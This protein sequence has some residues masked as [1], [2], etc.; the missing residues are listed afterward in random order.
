MAYIEFK[1]DQKFAEI[2]ADVSHN[3]EYFR[4]AG[5]VIENNE[6]I[7]DIDNVSRETI[8]NFISVFDIKT[9]IVWTDRGVHLY[10]VHS[11]K[12][13]QLPAEGITALGFKA[14]YKTAKRNKNITIKRN[15]ILRTIDNE[16]QREV[17]PEWLIANDRFTELYGH[18]E[19]DGRNNALF[20]HGMSLRSMY[21]SKYTAILQFINNHVF[22]EPLENNEF[23]N[24]LQSI[25]KREVSASKGN[26]SMIAK[27]LIELY[28]VRM[29]ED[30]L[31]FKPHSS[32]K[33]IHNNTRLE[34]YIY[35][36]CKGEAN[37]KYVKE[38]LEQ[39]KLNLI[40]KQVKADNFKVVFN[41]GVLFNGEFVE[42]D[43]KEFSPYYVDREYKKDV[44]PVEAVDN[45]LNHFT[46]GDINFKNI[47]FEMM[48]HSLITDRHFKGGLRS[49]FIIVGSAGTGKSLLIK[50]LREII[51]AENTTNVALSKI[52]DHRY[53]VN[54][55]GKLLNIGD[56]IENK[57]IDDGTMSTLK[58]IASCDPMQLRAMYEASSDITVTT[59]L[60]FTSN[61]MLKSF[62]KSDA[63][64]S[65]VKWLPAYN[66]PQEKDIQLFH[67]LTTDDAVS[68]WISE[69]IEGYKRLYANQQFT[70]SDK[71][72]EFNKHYHDQNNPVLDYID[73]NDLTIR[74]FIGCTR[75]STYMIYSNWCKE[76]NIRPIKKLTFYEGVEDKFNI[77]E[78]RT[79]G[80]RGWGYADINKQEAYE[81]GKIENIGSYQVD[82]R[83][84]KLK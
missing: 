21:P 79:K 78:T 73:E 31:Y 64:K 4:D 65:R 2:G 71:V 33:Y 68:Y 47:I 38:I 20:S 24:L 6:I 43:Y 60:M 54:L 49:F 55:K 16:N 35:D 67:K 53:A 7:I 70:E 34:G 48:A 19:G 45:Y 8:S 40:N 81:S 23:Q 18:Q 50:V 15:N 61:H 56:D 3:H 36:Y 76:M 69:I 1:Q 32:R 12:S 83:M 62:D 37:S 59:S 57:P 14:E 39:I 27:V 77:K 74:S 42:V 17:I 29:Y 66:K 58:N 22:S 75:T 25:T 11:D 63:Y 28:K 82:D 72:N 10:Y 84:T 46:D 13:R 80:S 30:N 26:E 52:S 41:N 51:G 5:Y 44:K 9:Q